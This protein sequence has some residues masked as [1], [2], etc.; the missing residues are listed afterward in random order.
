MQFD[1]FLPSVGCILVHFSVHFCLL[2]WCIFVHFSADFKNSLVFL[3]PFHF[4]LILAF[5]FHPLNMQLIAQLNMDFYLSN[6]KYKRHSRT[7]CYRTPIVRAREV[8][9]P[10]IFQVSSICVHV[11]GKCVIFLLYQQETK[12]NIEAKESSKSG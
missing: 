11:K 6:D 8:L 10:V 2:V 4:V 3:S 7:I 5:P 12:A 1:A 9:S